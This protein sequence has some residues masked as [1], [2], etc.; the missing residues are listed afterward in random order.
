MPYALLSKR[1]SHAIGRTWLLASVG[2]AIASH[3]LVACFQLPL[4]ALLVVCP[5]DIVN[6]WVW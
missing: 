2:S 3:M 5:A 4:N 6:R 1:E